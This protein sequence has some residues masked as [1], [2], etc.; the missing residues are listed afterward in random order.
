MNILGLLL[1]EKHTVRLTSRRQ[2]LIKY[3]WCL[4]FK[5]ADSDTDHYS[6]VARCR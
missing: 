1:M 6:L 5:V 3:T 4:I 2:Q